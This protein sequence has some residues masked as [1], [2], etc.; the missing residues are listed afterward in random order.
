MRRLCDL[1]L[2]LRCIGYVVVNG[3]WE[4]YQL[5]LK[6][7]TLAGDMVDGARLIARYE[8]ADARLLHHPAVFQRHDI[9]KFVAL[10]AFI[11]EERLDRLTVGCLFYADLLK[12]LVV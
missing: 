4:A 9:W 7:S 3:T 1:E 10:L 5:F 12:A 11:L 8:P 2:I 6:V